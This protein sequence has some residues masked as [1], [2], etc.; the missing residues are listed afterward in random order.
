MVSSAAAEWSDDCHDAMSIVLWSYTSG[1]NGY[2]IRDF[3]AKILN[4]SCIVCS[5]WRRDIPTSMMCIPY[6]AVD[7]KLVVYDLPGVVESDHTSRSQVKHKK[8]DC[9]RLNTL[10]MW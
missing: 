6:Q 10:Q 2:K 7:P 1:L 8:S 9:F 4:V 5:V 3:P